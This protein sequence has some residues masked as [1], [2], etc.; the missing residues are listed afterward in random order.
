MNAAQPFD[1]TP[2]HQPDPARPVSFHLRPL[3][4]RAQ[5]EVRRS[6]DENLAPSWTGVEIAAEFIVG[7]RNVPGAD[8]EL[9][10]SRKAVG[11]IL[12]G[13]AS[14]NWMVWLGEITGKLYAASLL[15]EHEKK[16]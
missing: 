16:A 7:W 1:F 10:F 5:S 13:D 11:A 15:E 8:G 9:A 14:V 2:R 6:L 3:T 12:G 4:L